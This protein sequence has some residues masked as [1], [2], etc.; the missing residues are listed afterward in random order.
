MVG[1]SVS[2]L[3]PI[4]SQSKAQLAMALG[5]LLLAGGIF[6][7]MR[8]PPDNQD[9][10]TFFYDV[11]EQKLFVAPSSSIPPIAGI[12]S[13]ELVAVRALVISTNGNAKDIASR[14]I[15]YLE[16]YGPELK[17]QLEAAQKNGAEAAPSRN[18]RRSQIFVRRLTETEWHAVNSPEGDAIQSDWQEPGPDGVTPVVC[19]PP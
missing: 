6:I 15:A 1:Q 19:S 5:L 10:K 3:I 12:K 2:S 9:G 18:E 7:W 17:Q 16:K 13:K 11:N 14:K 8:P 4:M